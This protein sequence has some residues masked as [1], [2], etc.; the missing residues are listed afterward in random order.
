VLPK[1]PSKASTNL[2][3]IQK[4]EASLQYH[5]TPLRFGLSPTTAG[6]HDADR[7]EAHDALTYKLDHLVKALHIHCKTLYEAL[8]EKAIT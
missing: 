8:R 2:G 3:A 4:V 5:Q 1:L 6:M 7:P